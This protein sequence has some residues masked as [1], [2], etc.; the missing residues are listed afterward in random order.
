MAENRTLEVREM[1]WRH[2]LHPECAGWLY[3]AVVIDLCSRRI[4]GWS[5]AT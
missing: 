3:L 1:G 5:I 2:H 4:V